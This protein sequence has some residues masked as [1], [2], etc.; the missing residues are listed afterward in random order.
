M[1]DAD[2]GCGVPMR[3]AGCGVRMAMRMRRRLRSDSRRYKALEDTNPTLKDT[4]PTLND[5]NWS[6]IIRHAYISQHVRA[7]P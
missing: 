1:Q 2:A 5:I 7:I 6:V 3:N 4:S